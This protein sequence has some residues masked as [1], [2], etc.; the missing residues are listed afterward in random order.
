MTACHDYSTSLRGG[1]GVYKLVTLVAVVEN[2]L[3]K[4]KP[5]LLPCHMTLPNRK[6]IGKFSSAALPHQPAQ[7]GKP[8]WSWKWLVS[9]KISLKVRKLAMACIS[10]FCATTTS[11]ALI[12]HGLK[13]FAKA[14]IGKYLVL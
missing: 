7:G 9:L 10:R 14:E 2:I 4:N 3:Q 12:D 6:C 5:S 1:G 13:Y 8:V 11:S